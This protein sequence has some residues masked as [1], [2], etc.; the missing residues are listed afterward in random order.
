MYVYSIQFAA[1]VNEAWR[2]RLQKAVKGMLVEGYCRQVKKCLEIASLCVQHDPRKRP[3]MDNIVDMLNETETSIQ[4]LALVRS[5]L[6]DVQPLELCFLPFMPS[7]EPKKNKVMS[8]SSSCSL[9]LN[10]KGDDRV[11]FMLVAN[12]PKRYLTK[13]PLCG[14]VPPR[15]A[16]TLTLTIMPNKQKPPQPSSDN[17]DFFMLY[18]VMLGGYDLLDVDKDHITIQYGNFFKTKETASGDEV[19]KVKLNVICDQPPALSSGT[20]SSA[21]ICF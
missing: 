3:F 21:V 2:K 13:K 18:S 10:N 6:L 15:C 12:S 1:Q 11:A 8:S 17:G 20:S 9:Q 14:V 19:Q 7:L 4:E 5:E 16:Y